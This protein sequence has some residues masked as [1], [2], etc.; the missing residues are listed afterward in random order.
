MTPSSTLAQVETDTSAGGVT[1]SEATPL[2]GEGFGTF[3]LYK[4]HTHYSYSR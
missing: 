4:R 3:P 2:T 1:V